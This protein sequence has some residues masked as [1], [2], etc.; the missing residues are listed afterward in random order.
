MTK[1]RAYIKEHDKRDA[2]TFDKSARHDISKVA[3]ETN[4]TIPTRVDVTLRR[5]VFE[6]RSQKGNHE[7]GRMSLGTAH[8][9]KV[10]LKVELRGSG[11][12]DSEVAAAAACE[13]HRTSRLVFDGLVTDV[14]VFKS[15]RLIGQYE[16]PHLA[17]L[18]IFA[19]F[20][21]QVAAV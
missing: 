21:V 10:A 16:D 1:T 4:K 9:E 3:N 6:H 18:L 12:R 13:V 5:A 14:A 20:Y 11:R 19:S 8:D 7:A 15:P 17:S 2:G